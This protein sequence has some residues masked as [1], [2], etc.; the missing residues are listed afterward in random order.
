MAIEVEEPTL[1]ILAQLAR[2]DHVRALKASGSATTSAT[3]RDPG[4]FAITS[5]SCSTSSAAVLDFIAKIVRQK[6]SVTLEIRHRSRH[7]GAKLV[8]DDLGYG[9]SRSRGMGR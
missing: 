1:D 4:V 8:R 9:R 2:Q 6:S 5:C 7:H 3:A